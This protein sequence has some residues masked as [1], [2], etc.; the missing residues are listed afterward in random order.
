[1]A[2]VFYPAILERVE[3][4]YSLIFP[5]LPGCVSAG[6]TLQEAA[7]NAEEALAGHLILSTEHGDPIAPRPN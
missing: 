3:G 2:T 7:R 5:D 6:A 4:G 1:M